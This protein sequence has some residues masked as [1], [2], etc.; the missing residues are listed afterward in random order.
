LDRANHWFA[1]V[2]HH[3]GIEIP[4]NDADDA[5][6]FAVIE[7]DSGAVSF[8][9]EDRSETYVLWPEAQVVAR[10]VVWG[11][12]RFTSLHRNGE[13][14]GGWGDVADATDN[15]PV[16]KTEVTKKLQTNYKTTT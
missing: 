1:I 2:Q 16:V 7:H 9:N 14:L 15:Y 13:R 8:H 4:T 5:A 3:L 12:N 11:D 6:A 10:R